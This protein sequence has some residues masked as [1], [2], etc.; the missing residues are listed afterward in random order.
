MNLAIMQNKKIAT[1]YAK[2]KNFIRQRPEFYYIYIYFGTSLLVLLYFRL[3][4]I[5][6]L[7]DNF[8]FECSR[9]CKLQTSWKQINAFGHVP[10]R[11]QTEG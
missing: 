2:Q 1:L 8:C 9:R 4:Y 5:L 10:I 6:V 11:H 3:Y 7:N